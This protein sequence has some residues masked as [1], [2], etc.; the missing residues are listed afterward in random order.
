MGRITVLAL[1][2]RI[3]VFHTFRP[4]LFSRHRHLFDFSQSSEYCL[5]KDNNT[6]LILERFFLKP[7]RVDFE[8]L[9]KLRDKYKTVLFFK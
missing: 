8:L 5:K 1:Y 3:S 9:Q 7:D 2:D 4:F 6:V